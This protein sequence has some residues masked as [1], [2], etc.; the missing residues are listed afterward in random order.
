[1]DLKIRFQCFV[2]HW[3]DIHLVEGKGIVEFHTILM[4]LVADHCYSAI[5]FNSFSAFKK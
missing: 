3:N 2:E 4:H 1:M 5:Y